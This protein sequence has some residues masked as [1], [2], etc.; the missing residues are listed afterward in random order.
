MHSDCILAT[1]EGPGVSPDG[2]T[3]AFA[4][5]EEIEAFLRALN[6]AYSRGFRDGGRPQR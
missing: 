2:R 1:V 6:F 3:Y 4:S 5:I